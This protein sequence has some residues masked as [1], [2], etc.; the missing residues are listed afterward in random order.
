MTVLLHSLLLF[1]YE[2]LF[3]ATY[4]IFFQ[5]PLVCYIAIVKKCKASLI[6]ELSCFVYL[7]IYHFILCVDEV[8]TS[9]TVSAMLHPGPVLHEALVVIY[10]NKIL[11]V[12]SSCQYNHLLHL[13]AAGAPDT[14]E[15]CF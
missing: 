10:S 4:Y 13:N 14:I 12:L 6:E 9:V 1:Y 2:N 15:K 11:G 8:S 3:G 5:P 7:F